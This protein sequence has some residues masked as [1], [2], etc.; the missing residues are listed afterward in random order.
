MKSATPLMPWEWPEDHWRKA[1]S[2]VRAGRRLAPSRW[3]NDAQ[4]AVALSFDCD[5][6]TFELGGGGTAVGRLSWGEFGRRVGVPRILSLLA[7]HDVKATFFTPAV[8]TL[9]DPSEVRRIADEKHEVA[10][11]GWIHENTSLL[12]EPVER[13]L[14]IRARDRI[15]NVTG[16]MPVGHRAAQWD[17]SPQTISLVKELGFLYDSSLMADEECYELCVDGE[18]SGLVEIPVEWL[19]D[20]AVYFLFSRNPVTRPYTPP[21]EVLDIF[22]RELDAAYDAGSIFQLVMHPFV[23]GYRSRIWILDEV[24]KHAKSKHGVWFGTHAEVAA[25]VKQ[26]SLK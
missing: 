3:P 10:V 8:V 26:H 17:L 13:D 20:D 14:M 12:S 6:E 24:I 2:R 18:P 7:K 21:R 25:W 4:C 15:A 23:I 9:I 11:H 19:R 1:I 16:T 22:I 5:H